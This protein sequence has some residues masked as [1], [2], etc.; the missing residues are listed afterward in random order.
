[1]L[2]YK[3][4]LI[5]LIIGGLSLIGWFVHLYMIISSMEGEFGK[6]VINGAS[7]DYNKYGE[8]IFEFLLMIIIITFTISSLIYLY[9]KRVDLAKD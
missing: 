1:V 7:I 6:V 2:S 8:L 3:E 9:V 5:V 4:Y